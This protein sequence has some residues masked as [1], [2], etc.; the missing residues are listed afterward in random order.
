MVAGCRHSVRVVLAGGLAPTAVQHRNLCALTN[1][2]G[3]D[4]D[5]KLSPSGEWFA[6]RASD[7]NDEF[8]GQ[9]APYLMRPDGAGATCLADAGQGL[10]IHVRADDGQGLDV[11]D[12]RD[13]A[14]GW[15]MLIGM[16]P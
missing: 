4:P 11:T 1:R 10:A 14:P 7:D 12:V 5:P 16:A 9:P 3:V 15:P 13:A 2:F 6:C 8:H